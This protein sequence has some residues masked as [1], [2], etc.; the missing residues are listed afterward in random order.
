[1][2]V[3]GAVSDALSYPLIRCT[4]R[5][6]WGSMTCVRHQEDRHVVVSCLHSPEDEHSKFDACPPCFFAVYD[7]HNGDLASETAKSKVWSMTCDVRKNSGGC[8]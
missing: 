7:G 6:S 8:V 4:T 2:V 1:M 3:M 5:K